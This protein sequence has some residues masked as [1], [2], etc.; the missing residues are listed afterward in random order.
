[1]WKNKHFDL[2]FI[3]SVVLRVVSELSI[4]TVALKIDI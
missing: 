1:M 4:G 2:G 3:L